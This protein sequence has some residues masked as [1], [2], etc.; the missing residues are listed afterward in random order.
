[1]PNEEEQTVVETTEATESS[2]QEEAPKKGGKKKLILFGGIGLGA[3]ALGV[4]L[5]LFVFKP[6]ATDSGESGDE[7]AQ[8]EESAGE[9]GKDTGE[10]K[11]KESKKKSGSHEKKKKSAEK[12]KSSHGGG[13]SEEG[14]GEDNIYTIK[15]IIVNPA[16]TGG[17]RFLSVSFAFDLESAEEKAA[18]EAREPIIRD[19]LITILSSKSVIQLTDSKQKEIIRYQ[20]KKRI[21]KLMNTDELAGV[22]YTDFVLQ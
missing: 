15:D 7:I 10:A 14:G 18:F 11:K 13:D 17:S 2:D 21:K 5:A 1:M 9:H 22:Y 6:S 16:G 20:I 8:V 4:V 12:K 19:A 3:V